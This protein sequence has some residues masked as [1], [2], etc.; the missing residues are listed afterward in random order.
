MPAR[1]SY[2]SWH[3]AWEGGGHQIGTD[4]KGGD[5]QRGWDL[6]GRR[7]HAASSLAGRG[8]G[9]LG[10]FCTS[11]G[12]AAVVRVSRG[13]LGMT[14]CFTVQGENRRWV[15]RWGAA[16]RRPRAKPG[17]PCGEGTVRARGSTSVCA[18]GP[19]PWG[20]SQLKLSGSPVGGSPRRPHPAFCKRIGTLPPAVLP[21]LRP[22]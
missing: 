9:G 14:S 4:P 1:K 7:P 10:A 8:D 13:G 5:P 15:G 21:P 19:P 16:G 6:R 3:R 2:Q 22:G 12:A 11:A 18:P 17:G 20:C